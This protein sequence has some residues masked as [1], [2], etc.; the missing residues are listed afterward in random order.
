MAAVSSATGRRGRGG[1]TDLSTSKTTSSQ[2]EYA[3]WTEED[4]GILL[5]VLTEAV[6]SGKRAENGFKK[7]TWSLVVEKVNGNIE[8]GRPKDIRSAKGR[9]AMVKRQRRVSK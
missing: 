9:F 1:R 3:S 5:D 7:G 2:R 4:D 8:K 6:R